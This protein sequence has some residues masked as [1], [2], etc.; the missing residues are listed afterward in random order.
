MMIDG[1]QLAQHVEERIARSL[2]GAARIPTLAIVVVGDDPVIESFVRIKKRV[3]GRLG[4]PVLEKRFASDIT[5]EALVQEVLR[6]AEDVDVDGI[7]VQLP[8][9]SVIDVDA[10]L[11]AI[12]VAKD[13]DVLS[14]EAIAMFAQG[15]APVLPPV[16]GA[17]QEILEHLKVNI[18]GEDVL[19]LGFGR[20]VGVPVSILF[21]HNGAHVTVIDKEIPDLATH[22]R[23]ARV[24]VS[25]V[26][27]P[28][29]LTPEM[30]TPQCI[31]I[32]AGT[33]ES[34]GKVVGDADS[35]CADVAFACTPVPGGVGPIA[36]VMLFKNLCVLARLQNLE[37]RQGSV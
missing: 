4:I 8:L 23:E 31:L 12:P 15:D 7:V 17:V 1:K 5:G 25:G 37:T 13:V 11:R 27:K 21:R 14:R 28:G 20:L 29:L 2:V 18:S 30:L 22:T 19:V 36:V 10:V 34:G 32:D 9:P 26:G 16:A 33:S 3:A 35:R 6:C 24:I